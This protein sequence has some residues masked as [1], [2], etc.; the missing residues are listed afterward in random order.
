MNMIL[1]AQALVQLASALEQIVNVTS[2]KSPPPPPLPKDSQGGPP[3]PPP[4]I[5]DAPALK[6]RGQSGASSQGRGAMFDQIKSGNFQL[7]KVERSPEKK[8]APEK[9][10]KKTGVAGILAESSF[11]QKQ[12]EKNL[13]GDDSSSDGSA[14]SLQKTTEEQWQEVKEKK[15]AQARSKIE[16]RKKKAPEIQKEIDEYKEKNPTKDNLPNR[17]SK[18]LEANDVQTA[19]QELSKLKSLIKKLDERKENTDISYLKQD[20]EAGK[21]YV[22]ETKLEQGKLEKLI[23]EQ[24]TIPSNKRGNEFKQSLAKA[25]KVVEADYKK[26]ELEEVKDAFNALKNAPLAEVQVKNPK[27]SPPPL[28]SSSSALGSPPNAPPPPP[29]SP[30]KDSKPVGRPSGQTKPKS[31]PHGDFRAELT[32][33]MKQRNQG[34]HDKRTAFSVEKG[35]KKGSVSDSSPSGS[36]QK[37]SV[38][39]TKEQEEYLKKQKEVVLRGDAWE[40]VLTELGVSRF[41]QGEI[42]SFTNILFGTHLQP[43]AGVLVPQ[44]GFADQFG[45][46][47]E[48]LSK[49]NV[50]SEVKKRIFEAVVF[51]YPLA[52]EK[53]SVALPEK[54]RKE[55]IIDGFDYALAKIG[56]FFADIKDVKRYEGLNNDLLTAL[57]YPIL[58]QAFVDD[59][60]R[61]GDSQFAKE[62]DSKV[63]QLRALLKGQEQNLKKAFDVNIDEYFNMFARDENRVW[64]HVARPSPEETIETHKQPI[65]SGKKYYK[66]F[67]VDLYEVKNLIDTYTDKSILRKLYI[68]RT[69]INRI[70]RFVEQIANPA[71][72]SICLLP[73]ITG[74]SVTEKEILKVYEVD[75]PK[76]FST[77][78]SSWLSSV[79]QFI[80]ETINKHVPYRQAAMAGIKGIKTM[81]EEETCSQDR[82]EFD[83]WRKLMKK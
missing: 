61:S 50:S 23:K 19:E 56:Y 70:N 67:Y 62:V 53:A 6:K 25:K 21:L 77:T 29:L 68:E 10:A 46:L 54:E 51:V 78:I 44:S 4:P 75:G 36:Q 33:E 40:K 66:R 69:A 16:A 80:S 15:L 60:S 64:C 12:R 5:K 65:P 39:P 27:G 76:D 2:K 24:E 14:K 37:R 8:A 32:A 47:V 20:L 42:R 9:E 83:E 71:V 13:P 22:E 57:V 73:D 38:G 58:V 43:S 72:C 52:I 7:K 3:P 11:F 18:L 31:V 28:P 1:H 34:S 49:K 26:I 17:L 41:Q 48:V 45:N 59:I 55:L 81:K 35:Q 79:E 30:K 82:V 74:D 63:D